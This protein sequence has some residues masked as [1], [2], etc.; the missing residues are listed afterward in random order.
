MKKM[1]VVVNLQ[2]IY[3]IHNY[4]EFL[5]NVIFEVNKLYVIYNGTHNIYD[6]YT[7]CTV[8]V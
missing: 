7:T 3:I 6:T 5:G 1:I 4:I 2:S 8:W